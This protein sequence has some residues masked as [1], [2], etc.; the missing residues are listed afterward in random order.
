MAPFTGRAATRV[1][2]AVGSVSVTS[3]PSTFARQLICHRRSAGDWVRESTTFSR[4]SSVR[5]QSS[6]SMKVTY[7]PVAA[8]TPAFRAAL[9]RALA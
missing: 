1:E 9:V 6:L 4:Q 5:H 7:S 3:L 2:I 8:A